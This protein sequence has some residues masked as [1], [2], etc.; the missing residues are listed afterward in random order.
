[1]TALVGDLKGEL[2]GLA[3]RRR[4]AAVEMARSSEQ[5]DAIEARRTQSTAELTRVM[6]QLSSAQEEMKRFA[7]TMRREQPISVLL[8]GNAA[9]MRA[10]T[11]R[12]IVNLG[13]LADINTNS[14]TALLRGTGLTGRE[15]KEKANSILNQ[16]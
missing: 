7:A 16:R 14:L 1:M 15:L 12:G 5:L 11:A 13:Q 4:A 8:S 10:L 3:E 2:D 9:A 6:R